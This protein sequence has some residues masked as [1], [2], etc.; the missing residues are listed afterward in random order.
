[1]TR[2]RLLLVIAVL[3]CLAVAA[4]SAHAQV[5]EPRTP[6]DLGSSSCNVV[7][8][9]SQRYVLYRQRIDCDFAKKWVKRLR[10]TRGAS[11]PAGWA[12]SSGT[13][14]RTGGYCERGGR[15][16]GWHPGD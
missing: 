15:H 11:K 1:M 14:F 16:F 6:R 12:C 5:G 10:E 4:G 13:Q 7:K 9:G 3:A 8:V 2:L